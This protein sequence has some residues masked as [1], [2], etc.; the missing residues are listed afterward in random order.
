MTPTRMRAA[1]LP[2]LAAAVL[3]V[4]GAGQ[5]QAQADPRTQ[6]RPV[7]AA[8]VPP[9]DHNCISP[10]GTNL[11]TFLGI[12]ERIIGPPACREAFVGERW[13]RSMPSWGTAPDGDRAHYPRGYTPTLFDPMDDFVSKFQGIRVVSDLGT[14][15][16]Q[17]RTFG[18]EALR[19]IAP[20][21]GNPFAF[22]ASDP[23]PSLTAGEHTSTVY[24]RLSAR[25]C[26]GLGPR[27]AVNCLPAG[28]FVYTGP[29]T[30][31]FFLPPA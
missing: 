15:R 25:H 12:S 13:V 20:F 5:A 2:A 26:D 6:T 16:E 24:M 4:S 22:L 14:A 21:D 7:T 10:D 19:R 18:P 23:L 3:A 30:I 8:A 17:S 1:V 27:P 29:T 28:E 11:N 31:R 9:A